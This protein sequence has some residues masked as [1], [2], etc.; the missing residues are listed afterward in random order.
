MIEDKLTLFSYAVIFSTIL[1]NNTHDYLEMS[2][3][4][5]ELAKNQKGYL[6]IESARNETG[7]TVSYW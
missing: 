7:I 5:E 2:I 3:R 1:A 6:G 4:M